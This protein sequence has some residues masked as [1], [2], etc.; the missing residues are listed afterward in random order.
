[1]GS[2]VNYKPLFCDKV[3]EFMDK[4]PD[5]TLGEFVYSLMRQLAKN[6]TPI[7]SKSDALNLTDKQLYSSICKTIK[8]ESIDDTPVK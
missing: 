6:G 4:C 7:D 8:E 1:M 2:K 5:H 3:R